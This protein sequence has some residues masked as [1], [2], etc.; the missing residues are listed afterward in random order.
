MRVIRLRCFI[1]EDREWNRT[2]REHTDY[3]FDPMMVATLM[4]AYELGKLC[5]TGRGTVRNPEKAQ[6]YYR[7]AFLGFTNMEKE[8]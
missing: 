7:A 8:V 2:M 4:P 1:S 3:F 6:N 5:E